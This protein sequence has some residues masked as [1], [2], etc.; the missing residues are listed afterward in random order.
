MF[1]EK[2]I[3][4]EILQIEKAAKLFDKI[5]PGMKESPAMEYMKNMSLEVL[6]ENAPEKARSKYQL[7]LDAANGKEVFY[8]VEETDQKPELLGETEITYDLD[9]IDGQMYMLDHRF[10][11]CVIVQFSKKMAED[12]YGTV[13]CNDRVLPKGNILSVKL[14]GGMQMC[15]IPVRGLCKEYGT[16]YKLLLSDFRDEDGNIM[17]PT[18]VT[19]KTLPK[20]EVDPQYEQHDMVALQAAREG[21]VLLKN[22]NGLLPLKKNSK[23]SVHGAEEF[24][25]G[26][27]GA[28]RINPRYTIGLLRGITDYSTLTVAEEADTAIIV[29]SRAS[30]ENL[31]NNAIKGNYYLSEK[32]EQM[33]EYFRK[34]KKHIVAV[35]S[36]GYPIDTRWLEKYEIEAAVWCGFSGMCGGRAVAEI[37]EG[38]ICPSAKLPDT[39][40]VDY[41]DIPSSRNFYLPEREEEALGADEGVYIDTCYEEGIYVGY[42]YF[43]TFEKEAA[44]P[45]GFGLSYTEFVVQA[46][47][48]NLKKQQNA[49]QNLKDIE[50]EIKAVVKN[51]G[52]TAGK[53]V[54]QIYAE[55]PEGKLEQPK[56]RL[57]GFAKT[58]ELEKSES[59]ELVIPIAL[60][61]FC[62]FDEETASWIVEKGIYHLYAGDCVKR[63]QPCG[64]WEVKESMTIFRSE[65]LMKCPIK[66]DVLSKY[67]QNFPRGEISGIKEGVQELQ[68]K[69]MRKKYPVAEGAEDFVDTLSVEE[70]ARLSVC[71]SHGWGMHEKGEA[72]KLYR[73][74][75]YNMPA[76]VVADGNNGVNVK[77]KNIGMPCSNTVCATWNTELAY[78]IGK[79]I[80]EEAKENEIQMILAPAMNLHRNPLNG[81]HPE[82]FSE[83]PYLTGIMAG[84]QS[85]G[86]EENGV[87]CSV[88]HVIGNNCEASRKCNQSLIPERALREL[89]LKAF[90]IALGVHQPDS[91]MTGYNA[92]NGCFTASDEEMIQG[93]FRN[94]FDFE[95]FV[96]T[97]WNSYDT[98]GVVE[99][100]A[101]GNTWMTPGSVDDTYTTPIVKGVECG[102][103]TLQR[104]RENIRYMLRVI[105]RRTGVDMGIK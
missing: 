51:I 43:E 85:K 102:Q 87:S 89:Y 19:V 70:L 83:D 105:Q 46:E 104:L 23:V 10:G 54:V 38:Q 60:R 8:E 92:V 77:Q 64:T 84:N 45:F 62:S 71:A 25:V 55:I 2:S 74:E 100:V 78:Q 40:S 3:L 91:V 72:G 12:G 67:K 29:I 7:L 63:L 101:A 30:G 65:H 42:R 39:W 4:S 32:E 103:I 52:E 26:A 81:R 33:L 76:Y 98:A 35:L 49:R 93:I 69:A 68:P 59:E 79:V 75:G 15:G 6:M 86:L 48:K 13:T 9:E 58:K 14:A 99:P 21:I 88:K 96:M 82:Y 1:T 41:W 61:E 95:G 17:D 56:Y 20:P 31:D 36:T 66:M 37:L 27:Y 97:D 5:A 94:E 34:Q 90:E 24:R 47:V 16:E 53:E 18:T 11:G 44:Y 73:L 80:A 50:V 22:K 57:V 28:G